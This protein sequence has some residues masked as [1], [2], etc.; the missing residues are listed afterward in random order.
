MTIPEI[1]ARL[2]IGRDAVYQMLE[3]GIISCGPAGTEVDHHPVRLRAVG[4][5]VRIGL[6]RA[7][8]SQPTQRAHSLRL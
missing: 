7:W 2:S 4:E 6:W 3:R 8:T 5:D 1:A